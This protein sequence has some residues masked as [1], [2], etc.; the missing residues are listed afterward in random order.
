MDLVYY[1]HEGL[2]RRYCEV[3]LMV[4]PDRWNVGCKFNNLQRI[5]FLSVENYFEVM[6]Y[7]IS[8]FLFENDTKSYLLF[9]TINY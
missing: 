2:L 9:K 4:Q 8:V 5:L 3:I 1:T 7:D 6:K